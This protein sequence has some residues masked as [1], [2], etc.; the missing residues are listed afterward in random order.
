VD[1]G[2]DAAA[3]TL[4]DTDSWALD[5]LEVVASVPGVSRV[6]L[7]L[8]EGGGRQHRFTSDDRGATGAPTWCYID[9]YEDV[10]L[11]SVVRTGEPV[12]GSLD[13]LEERYPAFAERQRRTPYLSFAAVPLCAAG[14]TLGG[15]VLYFDT[16]Q[17]FPPAQRT[18][19]HRLA[20]RLAQNLRRAQVSESRAWASLA[21]E[22][23]PPGARV[24]VHPVPPDLSAVGQVRA[25]V[26]RELG[27]WGL[28][29]DTV[30]TALLCLSELVTNALIHT[31]GGAEVR[32]LLED[33]VLTI[34]VRDGGR[35][36][37]LAGRSQADP[38]RAQGR[39][40]QIVDACADRWGSRLD[41]TGTTVWFLLET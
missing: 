1:R 5:A 36:A 8:S 6:G 35:E 21:D 11:N 40:L 26:S 29:G 28:D 15:V 19:L 34:S 2:A 27:E 16:R 32:T 12:I 9:A 41:S 20:E 31:R 7:A 30:D 3:G 4:T 13:G 18:E 22:P 39:G 33:G 37:A 10:P 14:Q 38:L 17:A 24:T 25:A 23:V